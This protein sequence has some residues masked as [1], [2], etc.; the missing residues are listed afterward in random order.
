MG[1]VW[2]QYS[3]FQAKD[4]PIWLKKHLRAADAQCWTPSP[5]PPEGHQTGTAESPSVGSAFSR[6]E[7]APLGD[8]PFQNNSP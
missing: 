4:I 3:S 1:K 2:T 7:F 8:L 5:Q 6:A